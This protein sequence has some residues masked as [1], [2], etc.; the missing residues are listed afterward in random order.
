[1]RVQL[2]KREKRYYSRICNAAVSE[3]GGVRCLVITP[4]FRAVIYLMNLRTCSNLLWW[5]TWSTKHRNRWRILRRNR[6]Q[7]QIAQHWS[8][9]FFNSDLIL[10]IWETHVCIYSARKIQ[11]KFMLVA[12][13]SI[14]EREENADLLRSILRNTGEKYN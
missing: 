13:Y 5:P 10:T 9:I 1:M 4:E 12:N 11:P 3:K 14:N 2:T 8:S 7:R 6:K